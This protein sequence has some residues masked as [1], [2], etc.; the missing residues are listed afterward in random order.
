MR[1]REVRLLFERWCCCSARL[2]WGVESEQHMRR[3]LAFAICPGELC[4]V[5]WRS[6]SE[7]GRLS[8]PIYDPVLDMP[9][10]E[11]RMLA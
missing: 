7:P 3:L 11:G 5:Q 4:N 9:T 2:S 1:L 10:G 8:T 6:L